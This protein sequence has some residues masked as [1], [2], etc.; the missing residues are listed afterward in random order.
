MVRQRDWYDPSVIKRIRTGI[1]I[2]LWAI[3]VTLLYASRVYYYF[4]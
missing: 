4:I 2:A 3:A 1:A